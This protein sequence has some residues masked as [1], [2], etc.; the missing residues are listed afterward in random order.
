MTT[1]PRS[2][3]DVIAIFKVRFP[4]FAKVGDG[5]CEG[6]LAVSKILYNPIRYGD[7]YLEIWCLAM[8]DQL[9]KNPFGGNSQIVSNNNQ[10]A[11]RLERMELPFCLGYGIS[12]EHGWE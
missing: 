8:A 11:K 1:T 4:E 10:Y 2:D 7:A 5:A 9:A 12:G 3:E 6:A